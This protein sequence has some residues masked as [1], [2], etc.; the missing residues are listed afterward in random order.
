MA[1]PSKPSKRTVVN[2]LNRELNALGT[3]LPLQTWLE[4][5]SAINPSVSEAL[6][7]IYCGSDGRIHVEVSNMGHFI[8]LTMGWHTV[9]NTPRVEYAYVS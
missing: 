7:G 6:D 3:N 1:N 4:A 8:W 9:L 5:A 2:G